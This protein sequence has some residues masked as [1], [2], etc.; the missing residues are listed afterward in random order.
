[1]PAGHITFHIIGGEDA[2]AHLTELRALYREVYAEPP[3]E[4]GD[5]HAGLFADRFE[6]QHRQDGFALV[7]ARDGHELK[8]LPHSRAD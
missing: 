8:P 6:V 7:E 2:A 4:W 3:Y 1:M 5:D